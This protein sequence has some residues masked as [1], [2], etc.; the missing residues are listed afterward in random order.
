MILMGFQTL[1]TILK[2]DTFM[3]RYDLPGIDYDALGDD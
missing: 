3:I 2:D 1:L